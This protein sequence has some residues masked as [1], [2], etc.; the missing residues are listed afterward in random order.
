[1]DSKQ[2]L[3]RFP[4]PTPAATGCFACLFGAGRT[5][6]ARA[7][8]TATAV[9]APAATSM[10]SLA[11]RASAA[12]HAGSASEAEEQHA[13]SWVSPRSGSLAPAA[14]SAP[15]SERPAR[16]G[17]GRQPEPTAVALPHPKEIQRNPR[18]VCDA[19]QEQ[20]RT[21]P[22]PENAWVRMLSGCSTTEAAARLAALVKVYEPNGSV[23]PVR[24]FGSLATGVWL[25][26]DG[27]RQAASVRRSGVPDLAAQRIWE[28]LVDCT[29]AWIVRHDKL[30]LEKQ[31]EV[32]ETVTRDC[33]PMVVL[34][35]IAAALQNNDRREL[36]LFFG[37]GVELLQS[38]QGFL[39]LLTSAYPAI[40]ARAD[41]ACL[42]RIGA[43]AAVW[44]FEVRVAR[45]AEGWPMVPRP[46]C[47]R[48]LDEALP[49][50]SLHAS[51]K[52]AV[53]YGAAIGEQIG[54]PGLS[55]E[56]LAQLKAWRRDC[57]VTVIPGMD[58]TRAHGKR[59]DPDDMDAKRLAPAL[60]A[61]A[62]ARSLAPPVPRQE[63]EG[64]QEGFT[65]PTAAHGPS[66]P[67]PRKRDASLTDRPPGDD[68]Q[69]AH[70]G[71]PGG[72]PLPTRG[73]ATRDDRVP[74]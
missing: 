8:Q 71:P 63:G 45:D 46:S 44:S 21:L 29:F 19:L 38:A 26:S 14:A 64:G 68:A 62:P 31:K 49:S 40:T 48:M 57:G 7:R 2:G 30:P 3:D 47:P 32:L 36:S 42:G 58:D 33:S 53:R 16:T 74:Q 65:K 59:A 55:A 9:P 12:R 23:D 69:P 66:A 4:S 35:R 1:M 22:A 25:D 27:R 20:I 52:D 50:S 13:P 41:T 15:G 5:R 34:A 11:T 28:A 17:R 37:G 51:A 67:A 73:P 10:Q 6:S 72:A 18:R 60:P 70:V 56:V 61:L 24:F 43:L 54:L 39:A